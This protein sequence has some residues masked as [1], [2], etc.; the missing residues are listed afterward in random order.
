MLKGSVNVPL[1]TGAATALITPF[2]DGK[3]DYVSMGKLIEWQITQGADALVIGGTTGEAATLSAQE[4]AQ[5]VK[6]AVD[7]AAGRLPVIA[8]AGSNCTAEAV[9]LSLSLEEAGAD[10]LLIVTPYYNKCTDSGLLAHFE[11]IADKVHVPVIMYSVPSRTG[12]NISPRIV[13]ILADHPMIAGIK[14]ASG[15]ISQICE[16]ASCIGESFSLYAGNDDQTVPVLS[17]GGSGCIST[18]ANI[19]PARFSAMIRSF[20][21]GDTA[22]AAREQV[23][24][25][26]LID[27]LFLEVNPVP[28]KA[29]LSMMGKCAAEYRLPMCPPSNKTLYILYDTLKEYGLVQ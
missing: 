10:G 26:P 1:F 13:R 3:I 20:L 22:A 17:L 4:K 28:V 27:A 23:A 2:K 18:V 15:N 6:F 16:I 29:A 25:K 14:E 7:L 8:G 19:I 11:T 12:V 21:A 9:S 5:L 24:L